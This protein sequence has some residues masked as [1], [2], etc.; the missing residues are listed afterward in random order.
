MNFDVDILNRNDSQLQLKNTEPLIPNFLFNKLNQIHGIKVNISL[1]ITF[2]K[3]DEKEQDGCFK[4]KAR[5]LTNENDIVE[6]ISDS[7]NELLNRIS[8]WISKGSGWI[9]KSVNKH[10]LSV[11]K[12][13]PLKGSTYIPISDKLKNKKACINI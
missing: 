13:I 8:N 9:I 4:T 11:I 7:N 5:E 2:I 10:E 3:Q 1:A 12:Y 6:V